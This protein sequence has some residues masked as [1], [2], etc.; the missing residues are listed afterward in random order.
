MGYVAMSNVISLA[1]LECL[2]NELPGDQCKASGPATAFPCRHHTSTTSP[3]YYDCLAVADR[4]RFAD[5]VII[6]LRHGGKLCRAE[7]AIATHPS[8]KPPEPA[9]CL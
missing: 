9:R 3:D 6:E 7:R 5:F 4:Y 2:R 1:R 8:V